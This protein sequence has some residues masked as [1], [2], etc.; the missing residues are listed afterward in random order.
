MKKLTR[1]RLEQFIAAHA[2][3]DKCLDI[4]CSNYRPY[5]KWFPNSIGVDIVAGQEVDVIASVCDLP[6][7]DNE[8]DIVLCT[9]VLEHVAD[10]RSAISEIYRVLKP[11]GKLILTTPFIFPLHEV[12]NDYY[13]FTI[14][15]LQ[16]ILK[17]F[18]EV[19][20]KAAGDTFETV[21]VLLE[22]IIIQTGLSKPFKAVLYLLSRLIFYVHPRSFPE[23]GSI[24]K[25]SQ[26]SPIIT[27]G[28][29]CIAHKSLLI[30]Q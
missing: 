7:L 4:G 22:R 21:A 15:G 5:K 29:Y 30:D 9:E 3:K 1:V 12:P 14:M 19:K 20:I 10:T 16:E 8:F 11:G 18:T 26:I 17:E 27:W 13:R 2:S 28:Y 24:K 23:F 6:F 25:D